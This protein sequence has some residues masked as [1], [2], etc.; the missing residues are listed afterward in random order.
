MLII[1]AWIFRLECKAS[2]CEQDETF[3][4]MEIL[5][6]SN[7]H[8]IQVAR[9]GTIQLWMQA[10]IRVAQNSAFL[11]CIGGWRKPT[12]KVE[13]P[14]L[15]DFFPFLNP[16]PSTLLNLTLRLNTINILPPSGTRL[17]NLLVLMFPYR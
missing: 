13:L 8:I 2:V 3:Q 17:R 14:N 1:Q 16:Y 5:T 11:P 9:C 15:L 4:Q 12:T 10:F 7:M 6:K